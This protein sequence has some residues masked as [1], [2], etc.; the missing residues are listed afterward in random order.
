MVGNL[1]YTLISVFDV[2]FM[3]YV[4]EV[5]QGAIGYVG[6]MYLIIF[7]LGYSYTKGT[8]IMIARKDG[9]G[10]NQT[11]G[12]IVDNTIALLLGLAVIL[13]LLAYFFGWPV[14][15][16]LLNDKAAIQASYDY[17][18]IR[19]YALVFSFVG[20]TMVAYYSGIGKTVVLA[21]AIISMSVANIFLN[22]VLIYG[23]LGFPEMGIKGAA[24][25]SNIGEA[26]S[27]VILI[28]GAFINGN[29]KAHSLFKF[30]SFNKHIIKE[31]SL[32]SLPL[33]VQALI[34]LGTWFVFFTLI[35]NKMGAAPWSA[36][37][38]VKILYTAFGIA[39]FAMASTINTI[40]GNLIGQQKLNEVIPHILRVSYI[41]LLFII[42][43]TL[44]VYAFPEQVVKLVAAPGL[45]KMSIKPT[46]IAMVAL[47]FYSFS[48]VIFNGIVAT[49]KTVITLI[50]ETLAILVYAG[51]MY[52]IFYMREPN[53]IIGWM[54]EWVYWITVALFSVAYFGLF[55]WKKGFNT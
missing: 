26:I 47:L 9:E 16:W 55:N 15:S 45:V 10:N 22:W 27:M 13:F 23:K 33:M 19:K 20:G 39:T 40:V 21:V 36:S 12:A 30:S 41:S 35:E 28:A 50:I 48:T 44:P 25:A 43:M 5:E 8:Q 31:M 14:L 2:G 49:G 6:H 54:S 18:N 32:I 38:N 24:I 11:I 4:G 17:L 46:L 29:Y 3:K 37:Q 51:F 7:M 34:G 42:V 52:Y 1:A 53:L